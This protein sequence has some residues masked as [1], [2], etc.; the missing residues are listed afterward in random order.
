MGHTTG[1]RSFFI[2][3]FP[4]LSSFPIS[5]SIYIVIVIPGLSRSAASSVY[6]LKDHPYLFPST[7]GHSDPFTSELS[8]L[9]VIPNPQPLPEV[10][11]FVVFGE[12]RSDD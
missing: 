11:R 5:S 9:Q 1:G 7:S 4:S 2:D 12:A 3:F 6:E 8:R 10:G